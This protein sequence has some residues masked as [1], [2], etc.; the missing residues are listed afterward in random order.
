MVDRLSPGSEQDSVC[1]AQEGG[2]SHWYLERCQCSI[3]GNS[4]RF[5]PVTMWIFLY[6]WYK[7]VFLHPGGGWTPV[8]TLWTVNSSAGPL[9]TPFCPGCCRGSVG[10]QTQGCTRNPDLRT[11]SAEEKHVTGVRALCAAPAGAQL[12]WT[13]PGR[14]LDTKTTY[15]Q[16]F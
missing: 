1:A 6:L 8:G 3:A 4:W 14:Y 7:A 10:H 16:R 15:H 13:L 12:L 5:G 11:G 2:G 9:P